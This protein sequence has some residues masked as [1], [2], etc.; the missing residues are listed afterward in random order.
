MADNLYDQLNRYSLS[1]VGRGLSGLFKG[2]RP[3]LTAE[4]LRALTAPGIGRGAQ[5][6]PSRSAAAPTDA[7]LRA[8]GYGFG[9]REY[10]PLERGIRPAGHI[11]YGTRDGVTPDR[12]QSDTYKQYAMTAPGQ[13]ERYFKTPEFDYAFGAQTSKEPKT[14]AEMAALAA[15]S[16]APTTSSLSDYY[17]SQSAMGRVN[18]AEIQKMYPDRPDLQK[19]AAENPML[20]QREYTK[21]MGRREA[22]GQVT[23][24]VTYAGA[25][26]QPLGDESF[27]VAANA[28]PAPWNTQGNK[29]SAD[30][31]GVVPFQVAKTTGEGL[32]Q[33]QTTLS[34]AEDFL[35]GF[36]K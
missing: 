15:Q 17:R 35:R 20:A 24:G 9:V 10:D 21:E 19:W 6:A 26:A 12:R 5:A 31:S 2:F 3:K 14:A 33:L 4:Q 29:V 28:V 34:K 18:Q 1:D 25:S 16:K 32:P 8:E 22:A 30:F 36:G 23:P 27:S 7:Q 13:F 11:Q